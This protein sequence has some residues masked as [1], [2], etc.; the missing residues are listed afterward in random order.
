MSPSAVDR[1]RGQNDARRAHPRGL[2]VQ[3][4]LALQTCLN[5][6]SHAGSNLDQ[7]VL[8]ACPVGTCPRRIAAETSGSACSMNLSQSRLSGRLGSNFPAVRVLS[9]SNWRAFFCFEGFQN[10]M[11]K[12]VVLF[13][14]YQNIYRR[15]RELFHDHR[16]S[17]HWE[18]QVYPDALGRLIVGMS[19]DPDRVLHQARVYRGLPDSTKDPKGYGA[20]SRQIAAWKK[21]RPVRRRRELTFRSP[22]ISQ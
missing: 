16:P 2:L 22:L 13:V 18:G 15:A 5:G 9:G 19:R 14:D 7:N 4:T 11:S 12:R 3:T 20:A 8:A 21:L 1:R 17:P 10:T 6:A